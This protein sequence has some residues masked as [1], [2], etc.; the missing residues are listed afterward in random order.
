MDSINNCLPS[1]ILEQILER[2]HDEWDRS[3]TLLLV[4]HRW[5]MIAEPIVWRQLTLTVFQ[6]LES[7]FISKLRKYSHLRQYIRRLKVSSKCSSHAFMIVSAIQRHRN[8]PGTTAPIPLDLI[9]PALL[10]MFRTLNFLQKLDLSGFRAGEIGGR[11]PFIKA[12]AT[13]TDR[14]NGGLRSLHISDIEFSSGL[15]RYLLSLPLTLETFTTSH[16]LR[17]QCA[18]SPD[19][20]TCI[21]NFLQKLLFTQRKTLKKASLGHRS[22]FSEEELVDFSPLM[23]L[24][25]LHITAR[26]LCAETLDQASQ[27]LSA[28]ALHRLVLDLDPISDNHY[29]RRFAQLLCRT[30]GRFWIED[31]MSALVSNVPCSKLGYFHLVFHPTIDGN[32]PWPCDLVHDDAEDSPWRWDLVHEAATSAAKLGINLTHN[33]PWNVN[34]DQEVT[35]QRENRSLDL[36]R[37]ASG[38]FYYESTWKRHM[39]LNI[40]PWEDSS[41]S[42]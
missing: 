33:K 19:H 14:Q 31:L 27:K 6:H 17:C 29:E 18:S 37:S 5:R 24:E 8:L 21:T 30:K 11:C 1:E 9:E 20:R 42:A 13:S 41:G 2:A 25:H 22:I 40:D 35:Q 39:G 15:V 34:E 26:D 23:R 36:R 32:T 10:D 4:C 16:D 38:K 7:E 28:P 12:A 3:P